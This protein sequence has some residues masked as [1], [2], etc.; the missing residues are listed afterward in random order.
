MKSKVLNL[1]IFTFLEN[2]KVHDIPTGWC[3]LNSDCM[4][5]VWILDGV[6]YAGEHS[7]AAHTCEIFHAPSPT[8]L[9]QCFREG[10]RLPTAGDPSPYL[11]CVYLL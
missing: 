4:E 11:G 8:E 3:W 1:K 2:F 10:R 9:Y 6:S 5:L 7:A